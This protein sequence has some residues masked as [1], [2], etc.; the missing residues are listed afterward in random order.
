M[1]Y[2]NKEILNMYLKDNKQLIEE[3]HL[4]ELVS[5]GNI[6]SYI[7]DYLDALYKKSPMSTLLTLRSDIIQLLADMEIQGKYYPDYYVIYDKDSSNRNKLYL[8]Y[9]NDGDFTYIK[10]NTKEEAQEYINQ[11]FDFKNNYKIL[12]LKD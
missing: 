10:F 5:N 8:S 3:N 12:G 1:G 9:D 7:R 4:F 6:I 2:F 11:R